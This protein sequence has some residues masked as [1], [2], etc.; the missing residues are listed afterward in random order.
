MIFELQVK[1]LKEN[2]DEEWIKVDDHII[3]DIF[4]D[5]QKINKKYDF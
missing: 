4:N 1:N 2:L 5:Y 3:K